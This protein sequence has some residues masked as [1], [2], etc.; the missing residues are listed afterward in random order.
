MMRRAKRGFT[1][2]ELMIYMGLAT[3]VIGA[4][5]G[6]ESVVRVS[7]I[8]QGLK[9]AIHDDQLRIGNW[10]R[11]DVGHATE[12]QLIDE[13]KG[14]LLML[15]AGQD[16]RQVRY[17]L[18]KDGRLTRRADDAPIQWLGRI[19]GLRFQLKPGGLVLLKTT[20]FRQVP[21][22]RPQAEPLELA[23]VLLQG[24]GK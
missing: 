22:S 21:R 5:M 14:L 2:I 8:Q 12:A 1:L 24:V 11:R 19:K 6:V 16:T 20:L 4:V 9:L 3:V 15:T 18:D 23:A 13:G 17:E 7:T 10:F